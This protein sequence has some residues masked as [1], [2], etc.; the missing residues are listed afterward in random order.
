[1]VKSFNLVLD[2]DNTIILTQ[3]YNKNIVDTS[4]F[5][6]ILNDPLYLTYYY[7][8]DHICV[9]YM[10]KDL[11]PFLE[12]IAMIAEIYVFTAANY[13][14]ALMIIDLLNNKTDIPIIHYFWHSEHLIDNKKDLTITN[15][16]INNTIIVDDNSTVWNQ[17]IILIK[18]LKEYINIYQRKDNTIHYSKIIEY[19]NVLEYIL[20]VIIK[21]CS[22]KKNILKKM[23]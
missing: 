16:D 6:F 19:D 22:M 21:Y 8:N 1:M 20:D 12:F 17:E 13:T 23:V 15:L 7:K 5:N 10:R 14:Y 9:V 4:I 2:L 18:P 11:I 3:K